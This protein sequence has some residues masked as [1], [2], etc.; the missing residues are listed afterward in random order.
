MKKKSSQPLRSIFQELQKLI[1]YL[2]VSDRLKNFEFSESQEN[3]SHL[4][5]ARACHEGVSARVK[6]QVPD[7]FPLAG[8]TLF[9]R[10]TTGDVPFDFTSHRSP[11]R[12]QEYSV[13]RK[14]YRS[15]SGSF[16][17]YLFLCY[18][19]CLRFHEAMKFAIMILISVGATAIESHVAFSPAKP[20]CRSFVTLWD[21]IAMA[22]WCE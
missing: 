10:I 3:L 15:G 4:E 6:G 20:G 11:R 22:F 1:Q 7:Y 16:G 14:S 19:E 2:H 17:R 9:D 18:Q 12:K 13:N 8:E 21:G 5:A